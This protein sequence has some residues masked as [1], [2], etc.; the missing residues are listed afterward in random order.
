M[1]G[2]IEGEYKLSR[3]RLEPVLVGD[4]LALMEALPILP[5]HGQVAQLVEQR[6]ENPRVGG[7]IPS[8]AI[9]YWKTQ[10][11]YITSRACPKLGKFSPM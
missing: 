10:Q 3:R 1:G 8:L 4:S 5:P 2:G 7:S 6:T 11:G 9:Q